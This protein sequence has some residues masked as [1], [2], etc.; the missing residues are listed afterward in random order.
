MDPLK[1]RP[2][3][4]REKNASMG[5]YEYN[6]KTP[7]LGI[8]SILPRVKLI[9]GRCIVAIHGLDAQSPKTW[10]AWK[11]PKNEAS[12]G[13][14]WLADEH[15]LPG[16]LKDCN[17]DCNIY[18]YDW[19]AAY[20]GDVSG[21]ILL[22]HAD[23]LLHNLY[24]TRKKAGTL[25]APLIFIGSCFSGLLVAKALVRAAQQW[26]DRQEI[27]DYTAGVVFLSTPFRGSA[28]GHIN[29][30]A[31]RIA[32]AAKQKLATSDDLMKYLR[33]KEARDELHEVVQNFTVMIRHDSFKFPFTCFYETQPTD[34]SKI[35]DKLDEEF[36]N[37]LD[38]MHRGVLVDR[39][40]ATLEGMNPIALERRHSMMHKFNSPDDMAFLQVADAIQEDMALLLCASILILRWLLT[41]IGGFGTD[42]R[43]G[44]RV[45][46]IGF[47][48]TTILSGAR[49]FANTHLTPKRLASVLPQ[50]LKKYERSFILVAGLDE[51]VQWDNLQGNVERLP[52]QSE[53]LDHLY[54][55]MTDCGG[56][57]KLFLTSRDNTV[58]LHHRFRSLLIP[59]QARNEDIQLC[60]EACLHNDKFRHKETVERNKDLQKQIL[61]ALLKNAQGQFLL[62]TLHLRAL[63]NQDSA[64]DMKDELRRLPHT[65]FDRYAVALERIVALPEENDKIT[66]P[67]YTIAEFLRQDSIYEKHFSRFEESLTRTC[68]TYLGFDDFSA[69]VDD[70]KNRYQEFPFLPYAAHF[71]GI[72][73]ESAL[74]RQN[75]GTGTTELLTDLYAFLQGE[76]PLGT[77]Q[78]LASKVLQN[79]SK[80]RIEM[81]RKELTDLHLAIVAGLNPIVEDMI[82]NA[83]IEKRAYKDETTIHIAARAS[84]TEVVQM[85]LQKGADIRKRNYSGKNAL[86]MIMAEPL[87]RIELKLGKD[88]F[89]KYLIDIAIMNIFASESAKAD[90]DILEACE[91]E[92]GRETLV[93]SMVKRTPTTE[94]KRTRTR[95]MLASEVKMELT[96]KQKE[97]ANILIDKGIELNGQG[98]ALQTPLQL[99]VMYGHANIVKRLLEKGAN[100][101]LDYELGYTA[102]E[103]AELRHGTKTDTKK[104]ILELLS[105]AM[106]NTSMQE[107][108][109]SDETQKL[110]IPG[111]SQA[112]HLAE[113]AEQ[114]QRIKWLNE[115]LSKFP[116]RTMSLTTTF[117][118]RKD[119]SAGPEDVR[120]PAPEQDT[121]EPPSRDDNPIAVPLDHRSDRVQEQ[122]F[123][124]DNNEPRKTAEQNRT[125]QNVAIGVVDG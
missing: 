85:L 88:D 23:S 106:E 119:S 49:S 59:I 108:A 32:A 57:C 56:S 72:R 80:Y 17:A 2:R 97:I 62:P 26:G 110:S 9:R 74:K 24:I 18:T 114:P 64:R 117:I 36:K 73:A 7:A 60:I 14:H 46:W 21:D 103:L 82:Q 83:D 84:N 55:V 102:Y 6:P 39:Y 47:G 66:F 43:T 77:L 63:A 76:I 29:A 96:A 33:A 3:V 52:E 67:H 71:V 94:E 38:E 53:L 79:P 4:H 5:W 45:S 65:V 68:I 121:K 8:L 120:A 111:P 54:Q 31:I 95:V 50:L 25:K 16:A 90:K 42:I 28:E 1:S 78:V 93:Q 27:L 101:W 81:W 61:D 10:I 30:T 89:I 113:K 92:Q 87:M 105:H 109:A 37:K 122:I 19:N 107:M 12:E 86:D 34:F 99:A 104:E 112:Q 70:L 75:P 11:D 115:A 123:Q 69:A 41:R 91:E 118:E 20:V 40:S 125:S 124:G 100:P 51:I 44:S 58:P 116:T 15:M 48:K 98:P 22:G 13:V 35:V